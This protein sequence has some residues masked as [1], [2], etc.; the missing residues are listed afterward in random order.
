MKI[1]IIERNYH[2][3]SYLKAYFGCEDMELVND[4]FENFMS[5]HYVQCVVSP[6]N[7]LGL[8]DGGYD[9]ALTEW[10][11]DQLQKRV[12]QYIIENYYGEQPVGTSFV[13]ETNKDHQYLIHTPTMQTPQEIEDPRVIY[14][15]MRTT[16]IEAKKHYIESILIPMFGGDTGKVKPQ[17]I[18]KM[19]WKAYEQLKNT[20]SKLDWEY[21]E[22]VELFPE[23]NFRIDKELEKVLCQKNQQK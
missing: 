10:Y 5:H 16:L 17:I 1:Y 18:A 12:Q 2:K 3:F 4:S 11:G 21:A 8:M 13:I 9:F 15:C 14:Q 23:R 7:A 6:A 19:M 20:P 22:K